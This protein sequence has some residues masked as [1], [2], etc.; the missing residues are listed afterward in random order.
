MNVSVDESEI[1]SLGE[2]GQVPVDNQSEEGMEESLD[3]EGTV[4]VSV[5]VPEDDEEGFEVDQVDQ[6]DGDQ[7]GT[8]DEST[9]Q[10][11]T[12]TPVD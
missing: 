8:D 5:Q 7:D 10:A 2:V 11:G 6:N 3:G 9:T 1:S 4:P 12:T